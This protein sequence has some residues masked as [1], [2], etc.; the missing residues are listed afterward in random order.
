[1]VEG[2]KAG[3]H[4]GFSMEQLTKPAYV[5]N[6]DEEIVRIISHVKEEDIPVVVAGGIYTRDDFDHVL[7][8]G[9]DGVQMGTRFVTTEECDA[10]DGYKQAYINASKEDVILV[11]SPVGMPGRAITNAFM[12][13]AAKEKIPHGACHL[14]VSTCKPNETPYC[15]TEALLHAAKGETDE[16]L[17]FAG[18]NAYRAKKLEKVKD[19]MNEFR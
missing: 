16:A 7:S 14:C 3:G 17:L 19:I 15:I 12:K 6:Y 10:A 11:K 1:M 2:P 8:L 18:T 13:R 9:A 4:L 5:E